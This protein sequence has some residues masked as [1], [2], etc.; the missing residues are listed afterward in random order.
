[1]FKSIFLPIIAVAAFIAVVGYFYKNPQKIN[2]PTP[3]KSVKIADVKIPVEIADTDAKR[4]KGLSGRTELKEDQGMLFVFEKKQI[5]PIFW[6]KD[7]LIPLDIIWIGN[8]KIVKI[9]ENVPAPI[10]GT[11]DSKLLNYSPG[12][13]IDYVLE[14]NAGFSDKNN[15]KV[16]DLVIVL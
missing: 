10:A 15:F 6:M 16:G 12:S 13:P 5:T 7:M 11:S 4:M 8:G 14:I 1:M 9:D 3:Q 2:I